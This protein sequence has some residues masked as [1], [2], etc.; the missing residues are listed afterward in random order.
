M[1]PRINFTE[2]SEAT[3]NFST[4]ISIE[5]GKIGMMYKVVLPNGSPL[6]LSGYMVDNHLRRSSFQSYW[7]LVHWNTI[8]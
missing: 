2:L 4:Y 6:Q 7:L 1:V 5:L 8:T 3:S